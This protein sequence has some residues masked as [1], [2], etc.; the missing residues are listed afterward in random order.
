MQQTATSNF[1]QGATLLQSR[2]NGGRLIKIENITLSVQPQRLVEDSERING[3]RISSRRVE[4]QTHDKEDFNCI[5]AFSEPKNRKFLT[6]SRRLTE[7]PP[8]HLYCQVSAPVSDGPQN[9]TSPQN[10]HGTAPLP[11]WPYRVPQSEFSYFQQMNR[12]A[13]SSLCSRGVARPMHHYPRAV[14]RTLDISAPNSD[15]PSAS[16]NSSL[17]GRHSTT[18]HRQSTEHTKISRIPDSQLIEIPHHAAEGTFEYPSSERHFC[19][20]SVD[21]CMYLKAKPLKQFGQKWSDSLFTKLV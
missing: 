14:C 12:Q 11:N 3:S 21:D 13:D 10:L 17:L 1:Q 18:F 6:E 19:L 2:C 20:K 15:P 16:A 7:T 4:T 8:S 9:H 5:P